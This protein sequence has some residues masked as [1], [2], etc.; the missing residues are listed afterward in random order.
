MANSYS[1][2]NTL[3]SVCSALENLPSSQTANCSLLCVST[4]LLKKPAIMLL[5][6]LQQFCLSHYFF[7]DENQFLSF[8]S[9]SPRTQLS[10][11]HVPRASCCVIKD[12]RNNTASA[13]CTSLAKIKWVPSAFHAQSSSLNFEETPLDSQGKHYCSSSCLRRFFIPTGHRNI[14]LTH[15]KTPR[16]SS[17][18][19]THL[20]GFHFYCSA[21]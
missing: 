11:Q 10:G 14:P 6:L 21:S 5:P 18:L 7:E 4:A 19:V 13:M 3:A 17:I 1:S 12:I 2:V 20:P 16:A 15:T 8:C 9:A